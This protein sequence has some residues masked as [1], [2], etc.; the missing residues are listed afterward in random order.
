MEYVRIADTD[1][2]ASRIGIGTWSIGGREWGGTDENQAKKTLLKALEKGINLIDTAPVYGLGRSEEIVGKVI[3]SYGKRD[4]II[5]ATKVG[6]PWYDGEVK[7]NTT[8]RNI[9]KEI[10]DSLER[11]QTDYIDLYQVHWP[12][13]LVSQEETATALKKLH[14]DG[15]IRAIGVSN[16]S[17]KQMSDFLQYA[18]LHSD[19]PPYNL[20]ERGIEQDVLP[21]CKRHGISTLTYSTLCRGLLSGKVTKDRSFSGDDLRKDADPKFQEPRFSQYLEAVEKLNDFAR[22]NYDKDVLTLAVRWVLDQ[23]VDIALSGARKPEQLDF[24][25]EIF[26]WELD[27]SALE[28][29]DDILD[30][31]IKD[32]VG[33]EFLSAPVRAE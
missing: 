31:T 5:L 6:L 32:P 23:G 29:I 28:E 10:E 11:L 2:K 12:D 17:P 19:Q 4:E 8:Q 9:Y 25:N 1:I 21:F 18:P 3:Q 33:P 30:S 16:Y 24:V 15:K 26:D 27:D 7:R 14:E 22:K 20:F 13:P